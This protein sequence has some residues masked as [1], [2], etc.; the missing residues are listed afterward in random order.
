MIMMVYEKKMTLLHSVSIT[1]EALI[2][3]NEIQGA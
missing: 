1:E 3:A 2:P